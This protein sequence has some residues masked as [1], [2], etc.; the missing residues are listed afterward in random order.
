MHSISPAPV[1]TVKKSLLVILF[2]LFF[3]VTVFAQN[4]VADSFI[5]I[6]NLSKVDTVQ[7][8]AYRD[9]CIELVETDQ[10]KCIN[11]Y[12]L[13]LQKSK[14][15]KDKQRAGLAL[16]GLGVAYDIKGNLDS[17]LFYLND[18]YRIFIE[19][20]KKDWQSHV[21]ND[22]AIAWYY[23]GSY[24]LALR[25]NITALKMRR[26]IGDKVFISRSLNNLGLVY[27][28]RKDYKNAI[29]SYQESLEIKKS[30][31]DEQGRL[32]TTL[33]IGA[34]YQNESKY[35][36]SLLYAKQALVIATSLKSTEDIAGAKANIGAALMGLQYADEALIY[37]KDAEKISDENNFSN[38]LFTIYEATGEAFLNKN[39]QP[40]ALFYFE[41]G[42]RLAQKKQRKES[43]KVFNK[44]LAAVYAAT[45]NYATAFKHQAEANR[46]ADEM[47]NEENL[48]QM[49][50]MTQVYKTSEKEK[51]IV[52]LNIQSEVD[53][54][55]ISKRKN[56]RNYFILIALFFLGMA[57]LAWQGFRLNKKKKEQLDVQHKIIE[58]ALEDK[59]ILIK[60]I[61]HRV[62][63][64]M[65]VVSSLL[66]LQSLTIKDVQAS[67]AVKEG[68]N[69]V[70]SMALIH[71]NLYSEDNL[72]GIKAKEYI[73]NLMQSL[74]DS[75]NISNDKIKIVTDIEDLNLDVDTMIP[76]GLILNELLSNVFK[77]AF[78][79]D[80]M[81]KQTNIGELNLVLKKQNENLY[82]K[83]YDN[84]I[85]F[86]DGLDTKDSKS[87]GL[88]MIKA[89]AQKLKAKVDIYNNNGAV[90]EM[91]IT[92][93]QMA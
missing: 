64:N 12:L 38:N 84:G 8:D 68:K 22:I 13:C 6:A 43:E 24:E 85:G 32:N 36:S 30:L 42:L 3:A 53:K 80:A 16:K 1:T 29:A 66:D 57:F 65:Q 41:K 28:A 89:F 81:H 60:E 27:R 26:E 25:N 17:C 90:V 5:R 51:E 7:I 2:Y 58:K 50:E 23:R 71:Q 11:L 75:Y 76:L 78:P 67:E 34:L 49:N 82:M 19:S 79:K 59:E 40:Q 69:R 93:Y 83:V 15:I 46:I 91:L 77:Y 72:K 21:L 47:L 56:E 74:C 18:A 92:K 45:G 54:K 73:D 88:K 9:A 87:F 62:K 63:N 37:L 35:D 44:K 20:G 52:A 86:P 33:N 39:N 55:M 31:K 61:H 4:T 70:Q 48:R 14:T 10:D